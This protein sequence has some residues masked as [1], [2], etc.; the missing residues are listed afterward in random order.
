[1]EPDVN[2]PLLSTD[3]SVNRRLYVEDGYSSDSSNSADGQSKKRR[4]RYKRHINKCH[5]LIISQYPSSFFG[6]QRLVVL[7]L[8]SLK[9]S[10]I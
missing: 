8:I 7:E 4:T 9:A 6:Y 1:M 5:F 10:E 2:T 3:D